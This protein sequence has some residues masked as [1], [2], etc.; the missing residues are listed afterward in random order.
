MCISESVCSCLPRGLWVSVPPPIEGER[1][2][3]NFDFTIPQSQIQIVYAFGVSFFIVQTSLVYLWFKQP[4]SL[5]SSQI[6]T[7]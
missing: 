5:K 6:V 1:R 2:K 4:V 7:I 3:W